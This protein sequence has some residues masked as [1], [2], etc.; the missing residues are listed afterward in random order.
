[1]CI[2]MLVMLFTIMLFQSNLNA[3]P[4]DIAQRNG[5]QAREALVRNHHVLQ[6]YLKRM[7]PVTKLL[8][9]RGDNR[10][11]YVR[12]SAADLY[13]FLVMA[14][15]FTDRDVYHNQMHEIL[16]Q[17][18]WHSTRIGRLSDNVMP[19]GAGFEHETADLNRIIFGSCE[20]VKDGLIPL[21]ELLGHHAWYERMR[22]IVDDMIKHAPYETRYGRVPSMSDEVNGEFLQALTRLSYLT[23]EPRY[24]NQAM[25]IVDFYFKEVIPKS[26]GLPAHIWD[27]DTGQP[28][29]DMFNFADHGNE[30]IGGLSEWVFFLKETGHPRFTDF[31]APMIRLMDRLLEVGL[32]ADGVW[33]SKIKPSNMEIIDKRH[34]HCWGYLFNAVYTTWLISG[35][36][37]F[38]QATQ[39]ALQ[40]VTENPA[41]LDDPLGSGR[42]YGSNAYSDA[43]E[44]AIVFLNR[45][46][47]ERTSA[48][49][50]ACVKRFL[51]R[52]REDGI[53]ENWYG[54]GNYVRTALMFALMKSQG[55]WLE[56]WRADLSLGA[57]RQDETLL[58]TLE[59]ESPW[60][61]V[62]RFDIPR[63]RLF[64]NLPVNYPRLNEFPEWFVVD[65][66]ALYR[67]DIQG[68]HKHRT[69]GELRRGLAVQAEQ[70]SAT[71]VTVHSLPGPPYRGK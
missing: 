33:I 43:I 28:E 16:R 37:R 67:V 56:P 27:L 14:A 34:A 29:T 17:E 63:H 9:R 64:F 48:V 11:W 8:P 58:L 54:D 70:G 61:G 31:E 68:Q 3:N 35:E 51:G 60:E 38:L 57:V 30:I 20:Y 24:I 26:N 13:P 45:L 40:A 32:N 1:M 50:D 55:A 23:R 18:L 41:Y 36:Q 25:A 53:I 6:A 59:C 12:D 15:Y 62:I 10:T 5:Q 21:T 71:I 2:K 49:L 39:Q 42:N 44:S 66:D 22:G 47:N 52:Q 69:G 46:P 7:D 4:V 65:Q 19:G